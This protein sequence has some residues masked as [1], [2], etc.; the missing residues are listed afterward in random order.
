MCA[1]A[2]PLT[3]CTPTAPYRLLQVIESKG[4]SVLS[5]SA[6]GLGVVDTALG[7]LIVTCG[8][9][10]LFA[11]RLYAMLVGLLEVA[12]I[13]VAALFLI[14]DTQQTII[15]KMN[16]PA[17]IRQWVDDHLAITGYV[18]IAVVCFQAVSLVLVF[19]QSCNVSK[20]FEEEEA[21]RASLLSGG[22]STLLGSGSKKDRLMGGLGAAYDAEAGFP[23][24]SDRYREK[25][26]K[27][28]EKYGLK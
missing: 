1:L 18:L 3:H 11:L 16:P 14:E 13:A 24:A 26:S 23:S 7:L 27:Y 6:V 2:L 21:D 8:Y 15:D 25:A 28:Y 12:Q 22:S 5:G 20:S 9:R 10:Y 17:D 19:V 4:F